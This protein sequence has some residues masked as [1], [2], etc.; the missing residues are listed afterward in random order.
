MRTI[1]LRKRAVVHAS[2]RD[3]QISINEILD[4]SKA[5]PYLH[6]MHLISIEQEEIQNVV[7]EYPMPLMTFFDGMFPDPVSGR[8]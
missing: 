3:V 4:N 2:H 7:I 6:D 8:D 5:S 1:D